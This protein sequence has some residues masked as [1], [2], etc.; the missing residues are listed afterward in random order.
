MVLSENG[1][2]WNASGAGF[3]LAFQDILGATE[4]L[5]ST[6]TTLSGAVNFDILG[7]PSYG[8][9]GHPGGMQAHSDIVAVAMESGEAA[10]GAVYFLEVTGSTVRYL[11][12][13]HLDG[14][15]GEPLQADQNAAAT[16]GF[17]RLESGYYLLAVSGKIHGTQGIWFYES[18]DTEINRGTKWDF[19]D[20]YDPP[21]VQYGTEAD[22]CYVGAGG[23]LN[24]VTD[25]SGDIY[26]LAMHGTHG[27][28]FKNEYEYLQVFHVLQDEG[29]Q[30]ALDKVVQQRDNLQFSAIDDKSFRWSGGVY[31]AR[32]GHI[33]LMNTERRT[34][35][36]DNDYVDGD[37]YLGK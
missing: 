23:G 6:E 19:V 32:D 29:G 17:V 35:Q 2:G 4:G 28:A 20:F 34:N 33:A 25:C 26:L 13:L 7:V 18:S 21:C 9:H 14:S 5:Y 3:K 27:T 24:L 8:D 37:V 30:V 36:G 10:H 22:D 16:V 15:Q 31:V 12:T 1:S 11:S